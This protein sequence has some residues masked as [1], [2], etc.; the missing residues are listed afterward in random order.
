M[1]TCRSEN[2]NNVA[3]QDLTKARMESGDLYLKQELRK[4]DMLPRVPIISPVLASAAGA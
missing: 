4:L 3:V 2:E 1:N